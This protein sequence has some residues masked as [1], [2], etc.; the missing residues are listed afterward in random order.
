MARVRTSPQN[1]DWVDKYT[2]GSSGGLNSLAATVNLTERS[3]AGS[4]ADL[5]ALAKGDHPVVTL[6]WSFPSSVSL[7]DLV[8]DNTTHT[9][10][11]SGAFNA[12]GYVTVPAPATLLLLGTGLVGLAGLRYRRKRQG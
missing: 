9:T 12:G 5:E 7:T 3:Y 1:V 2:V 6:A 11:Y 8:K 10:S 4:N